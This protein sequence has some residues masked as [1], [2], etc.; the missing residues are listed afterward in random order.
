MNYRKLFVAAVV[1]SFQ[2][3]TAFAGDALISSDYLQ[4]KWGL[5]GLSLIHI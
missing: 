4:G 5:D 1:L 3:L 2:S